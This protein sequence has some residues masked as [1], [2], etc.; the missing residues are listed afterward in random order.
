[1]DGDRLELVF[2]FPGVTFTKGHELEASL[3]M[4]SGSPTPG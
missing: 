4:E 1:M 3:M 2:T